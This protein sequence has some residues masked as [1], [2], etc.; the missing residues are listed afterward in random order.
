MNQHTETDIAWVALGTN[1]GHRAAALQRLRDALTVDGVRIERRSAEI[2]TRPVGPT[3]QEDFHNQLVVL[4]SPAPWLPHRW[5][6]HCKQAEVAAGR[7]ETYRWGPRVAD[8]DI[9]LLGEDGDITVEEPDLQ[10]PHPGLLSRAYLWRL[11]E[12]LR[13]ER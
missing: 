7:R 6:Q 11:M 5:L 10:V 8:A 3:A 12:E 1:V 13:P 2:L 4:R 9:I